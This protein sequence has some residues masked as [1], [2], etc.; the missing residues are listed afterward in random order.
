MY[1]ILFLLLFSSRSW[2][3]L[4]FS[5]RVVVFI[6]IV[7][8]QNTANEVFHCVH[9]EC[10]CRP[11]VLQSYLNEQSSNAMTDD[12]ETDSVSYEEFSKSSHAVLNST[13]SNNSESDEKLLSIENIITLPF[14]VKSGSM[15]LYPIEKSN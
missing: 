12:R 11:D 15:N 1:S 14:T 10:P 2:Q 6:R 7:G 13:N 9:F 5:P 8:T 3:I 4:T